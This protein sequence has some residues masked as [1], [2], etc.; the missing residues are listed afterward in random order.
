MEH[1]IKT[2]VCETPEVNPLKRPSVRC[3]FEEVEE[4]GGKAG[5]QQRFSNENIT[6]KVGTRE[7][8]ESRTPKVHPIQKG[9]KNPGVRQPTKAVNKFTGPYK[10]QVTKMPHEGRG[11]AANQRDNDSFATE[12]LPEEN[13]HDT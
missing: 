11:G 12:G 3:A 13:D 5:K 7:R 4:T 9:E 8:P 1:P 6:E 2:M 10:T